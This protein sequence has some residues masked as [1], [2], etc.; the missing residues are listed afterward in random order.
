MPKVPLAEWCVGALLV[1]FVT[2]SQAAT[3]S[4]S[5]SSQ[6]VALGS[7]ISLQLNMDFTD[8]PTLGGGLDIYYDRSLLSFVSFTFDPALGDDPFFATTAGCAHA[9]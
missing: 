8:D 9:G 7:Q 2:T 6:Y 1:S 4:L 3:I 5:P